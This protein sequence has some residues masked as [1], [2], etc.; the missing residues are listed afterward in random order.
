M[1]N[2]NHFDSTW[3]SIHKVIHEM[4]SA[5]HD[6]VI[7]IEKLNTATKSLVSGLQEIDRQINKELRDE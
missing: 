6:I 7:A 5:I 1:N 3:E 4:K 2:A